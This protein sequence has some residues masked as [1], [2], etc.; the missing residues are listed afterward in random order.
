MIVLLCLPLL[1]AGAK[2]LNAP[3]AEEFATLK[4]IFSPYMVSL[5]RQQASFNLTRMDH[6]IY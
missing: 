2:V 5:T 6:T 3:L 4:M 1:K